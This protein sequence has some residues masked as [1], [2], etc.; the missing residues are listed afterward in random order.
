MN[1]LL[2]KIVEWARRQELIRA[3]ILAGST[4]AS[5]NP[6]ELTDLDIAMFATDPTIYT[7]AD[8]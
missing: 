2:D 1:D 5:S 6:D 8:G 3:L 7:S 4:V